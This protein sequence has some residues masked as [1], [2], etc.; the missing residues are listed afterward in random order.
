MPEWALRPEVGNEGHETVSKYGAR[1]SGTSGRTSPLRQV[2]HTSS[3][4]FFWARLQVACHEVEQLRWHNIQV[5]SC[6][7]WYLLF[8]GGRSELWFSFGNT[9]QVRT[10][11]SLSTE[12]CELHREC[13]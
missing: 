6:P 3:C 12:T 13:G 10:K 1:S 5:G 7:T 2:F 8:W 11:F 9:K 4:V